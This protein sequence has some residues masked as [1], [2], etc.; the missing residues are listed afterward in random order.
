MSFVK[1]YK[2][3]VFY[4]HMDFFCHFPVYPVQWEPCSVLQTTL[5]L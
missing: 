4:P 5:D 2:F 3:P 1:I